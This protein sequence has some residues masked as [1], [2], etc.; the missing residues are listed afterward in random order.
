MGRENKSMI[1][2][3][4]KRKEE[5]EALKSLKTSDLQAYYDEFYGISDN[6][7]LVVIGNFDS[8]AIKTYFEDEYSSFKI[9]H[10][11]GFS[12]FDLTQRNRLQSAADVLRRISRAEDRHGH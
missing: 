12:C 9:P 10:D 6:A 3:Q 5:I 4:E 1:S 8:K 11:K 2:N 7:T